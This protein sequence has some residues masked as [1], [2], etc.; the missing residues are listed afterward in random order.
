MLPIAL[1]ISIGYG[2]IRFGKDKETATS[3]KIM[4]C[5]FV[6]YMAGL[7][8]L[9]DAQDVIADMWYRI[10]YHM[11]S[12]SE[13]RLFTWNGNF[14]PNFWTHINGE[15][16]GNLVMFLPFGI[17]FPFFKKN[18]T[19]GKTLLAGIICI[20]IIECLQPVFGR[21]FD[22]ND[23]IMNFA[24]VALSAGLFLLLKKLIKHQ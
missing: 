23:I 8:C 12:G 7:F 15:T 21:A 4:S 1:I 14:I 19:F 17:L 22:V 9:V 13:I 2:L 10:L 6:C 5:L 16:I 3:T 24:G 20:L 18:V 11:N